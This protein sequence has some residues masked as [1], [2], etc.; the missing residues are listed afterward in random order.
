M[1]V[2]HFRKNFCF[3]NTRKTT[4][5]IAPTTKTIKNQVQKSA[6][7]IAL[8]LRLITTS[9][10]F[11]LLYIQIQKMDAPPCAPIDSRG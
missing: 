10:V 2:R 3:Y 5:R 11:L 7:R 6:A 8:L 9:F 1:Q 4:N